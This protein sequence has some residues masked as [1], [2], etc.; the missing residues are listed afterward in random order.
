MLYQQLQQVRRQLRRREMRVSD[1]LL[2]VFRYL[3][4]RLPADR[5]IW[6][7][8]ELLGYRKDDLASL[9]ERPR[10]RQFSI[11]LPAPKKNEMEVPMYRFLTGAWGKL[12]KNGKLVCCDQQHLSEKSIFCNIGIQQIE[13]QLDDMQEPETSLFSMST[14]ESSGAEF[15]CWSKELARV[16][17]AVRLK[18][19][20]FIETVILELKLAPNER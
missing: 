9:Y 2:I 3:R 7:N 17:D 19:V 15:Y 11:F 13:T 1:A 12:D 8:R 5:L 16:Y 6:L 14:D 10:V 18:L 20:D 4:D